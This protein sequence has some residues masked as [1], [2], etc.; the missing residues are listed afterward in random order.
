MPAGT[1]IRFAGGVNVEATVGQNGTYSVLLPEGS[2][3]VLA[4]GYGKQTLEV[5][6]STKDADVQLSFDLL[7]DTTHYTVSS[8][9]SSAIVG[10]KW[11]TANFNEL[12]DQFV[13]Y[14][15]V[16]PVEGSTI[17]SGD[18]MGIYILEGDKRYGTQS[19]CNGSTLG[20][21]LTYNGNEGKKDNAIIDYSN[22]VPSVDEFNSAGHKYALVRNGSLF[23]IYLQNNGTYVK[24][25]E[26]TNE[27]FTGVQLMN[28]TTNC[29]FTDIAYIPGQY[30]VNQWSVVSANK[31]TEVVVFL[32]D[33]GSLTYQ[34][35]RG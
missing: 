6:G 24:V 2:Y 25:A 19:L 13:L 15:T 33:N 14:Y 21:V 23:Y 22:K 35:A 18:N 29:R 20:G 9:E 8:D 5:T 11:A 16:K 7:A 27:N 17:Q 32:D 4:T 3:E 12:H 26:F 34:V 30:A 28:W 10:T 31:E 1:V